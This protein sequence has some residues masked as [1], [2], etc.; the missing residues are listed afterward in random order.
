MVN[1]PTVCAKHRVAMDSDGKCDGCTKEAA[2][3]L[4]S[5]IA[6]LIRIVKFC[7]AVAIAAWIWRWVN[8]G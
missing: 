5:F 8:R 2:L 4:L 1:V 7:A 6:M 3:I